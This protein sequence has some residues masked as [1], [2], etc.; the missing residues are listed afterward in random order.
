MIQLKI[1]K[2]TVQRVQ[3][4]SGNG[5]IIPIADDPDS[6]ADRRMKDIIRIDQRFEDIDS[7]KWATLLRV[8]PGAIRQT[9]TWKALQNRKSRDS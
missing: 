5:E 3:I 7:N 9:E 1:L 6:S 4:A 2:N 8:T